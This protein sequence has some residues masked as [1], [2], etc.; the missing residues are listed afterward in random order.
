[1][2]LMGVLNK[3]NAL[4]PPSAYADFFIYIPRMSKLSS[5]YK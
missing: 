3:E 4:H 2:I 5:E 1:M